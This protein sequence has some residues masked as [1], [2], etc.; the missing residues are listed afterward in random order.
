MY[1]VHVRVNDAATGRPTPVRL[2]LTDASGR[3]WPPLG[4]PATFAT[5][6]GVDVGGAVQIG[7]KRYWYVDGACEVPLPA[8][9]ITAE[10]SKGPE[11]TPVCRQVQ[12]ADGQISLRYTIER[13]ANPAVQGWYPGDVRATD[14]SPHAALLE[15]EAEGL[16]VVQLLAYERAV[17]VPNLLAFSGSK[18][19]LRTAGCLVAVNTLNVHP[20]LGTLALLHCHR[21]VFP[22]RADDAAPWSVADWCDQCHRKTGLVVW[23]DLPRLEP[24][25]PQGEALAALVL[26]KI[27]AFEISAF[28]D[29]ESA[30]LRHYYT[31]L[32]AGCRP[33]L[34]G[35]SGKASNALPLGAVRTYARLPVDAPLDAG[36][37]I[38][39]VRAGRTFVT[40]GPLLT[41]TAN[42][43]GPGEVVRVRPDEPVRVRAEASSAVPFDTLELVA[44]G[45][46]IASKSVS[47][48][49]P[50]TVEAEFV[51]PHGTIVAAR[52]RSGTRLPTGSV[53]CAHT[54]PAWV[55]VAGRPQPAVVT[56]L[57]DLLAQTARWAETECRAGEKHRRQLLEV[58]GEATA[59]LLARERAG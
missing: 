43:V 52:C 38:E 32:A 13:W 3:E 28:P 1:T 34:V 46:V 42:N 56:P 23:P 41:L 10:I 31:L 54:T 6:P 55:E 7:G 58:I 29:P 26:G 19:C 47:A 15:G 20:V 35:G 12:L 51:P 50:T 5:E 25:H 37:W 22:L 36:G 59:V 40:T 14:L 48:D 45:E 16:A 2:R 24:A 44:G 4:R 27:D 17:A 11:Y 30:S 53:V 33:A 18:E 21:P 8:G 49:G 39:A 57:L 9:T